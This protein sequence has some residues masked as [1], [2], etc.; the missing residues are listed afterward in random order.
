[1]DRA[2]GII[3]TNYDTPELRELIN[4]R[5][6][7]SV[8][9]AGRYRMIDFALSN[10]VNAGITSVGLITPYKYRSLLD[11]VGA[12]SEWSLDRKSGGL[13]VLPGSVFGISSPGSR[14]LLRDLRRNLVFLTRAAARYVVLTTA[15]V[16][17]NMDFA[18]LINVH[19]KSGADIT[20]ACVDATRDEKNLSNVHVENGKVTGTSK[21][22]KAG[23]LAFADT[24]VVTYELLMKLL[25]WYGAIDYLDFFEVISG[26]YDKMDVRTYKFEGYLRTIY[27]AEN[28]FRNSMNLLNPAVADEL[29]RKDRPIMTKITDAPPAKYAAGSK[30]TNSLIPAGCHIEGTVED[31]VLFRGVTVCKGAVVKNSII[32]QSC[33]IGENAVVENAIIDRSNKIAPGTVLKGSPDAILIKEKNELAI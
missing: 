13:F 12:G 30:V 17:A 4:G 14:F 2:I 18:D 8:P 21:G 32:M 29:F 20:M 1:M 6:A 19:E 24:F 22:V 11:H 16:V 23:E 33:T 26:D 5:T 10:M 7:A 31:S 27:A 3:T 28:Y 9:F 15:N 25:E